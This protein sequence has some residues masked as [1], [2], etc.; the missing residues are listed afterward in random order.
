MVKNGLLQTHAHFARARAPCHL[1]AASAA[2]RLEPQRIEG[3]VVGFPLPVVYDEPW[4]THIPA[5][6]HRPR[7]VSQRHPHHRIEREEEE[8]R[9]VVRSRRLKRGDGVRGVK[10]RPWARSTLRT[11]QVTR[12]AVGFSRAWQG[13]VELSRA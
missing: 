2:P 7:R 5:E 3:V 13:L 8:T 6:D 1:A 10:V 4:R 11:H 12:Q 9:G